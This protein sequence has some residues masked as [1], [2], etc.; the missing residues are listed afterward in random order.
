LKTIKTNRQIIISGGGLVTY[1]I[2]ALTL[3]QPYG[4][5][6]C[7]IA[8][9]ISYLVKLALILLYCFVIDRGSVPDS[10]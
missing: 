7:C 5:I 4:L 2:L 8:L 9:L 1:I 3:Y 10:D 6:G